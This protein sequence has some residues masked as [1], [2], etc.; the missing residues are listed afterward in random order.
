MKLTSLLFPGVMLA[1]AVVY[2]IMALNMPR[3]TITYPGPGFFPM[4]V[5]VFLIATVLGCLLQEILKRKP[6][7]SP[8]S[9]VAGEAV[10]VGRYFGKTF[11]LTALMIGY[12]LALTP[13]GFPIAICIFMVISIR[14]FGS[15][16][17]VFAVV[18]AAVITVVSYIS[19][20]LWLKVPLPL[21]I[22]EQIL[23]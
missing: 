21:G 1:V 11:Q 16:H 2:E 10:S 18:I 19:F 7:P 23:G 6:D 17:W 14:I 22:L 4:A 9:P 13:L 8:D 12:I 15:R 20:V 3:G 5:G